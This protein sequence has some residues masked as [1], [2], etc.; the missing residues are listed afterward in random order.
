[1]C[2]CDLG[3][4]TEGFG[5]GGTVVILQ[6]KN[7]LNVTPRI[8]ESCEKSSHAPGSVKMFSL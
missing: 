8:G 6:M 4:R 1:M 5:G 2:R 3:V 7:V